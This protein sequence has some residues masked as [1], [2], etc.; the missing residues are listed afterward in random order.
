MWGDRAIASLTNGS[1]ASTGFFGGA[2]PDGRSG[3]NW[4]YHRVGQNGKA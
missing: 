1:T 3:K 2:N 4:K